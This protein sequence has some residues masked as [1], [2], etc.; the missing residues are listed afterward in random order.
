VVGLE[1]D[2]L[3]GLVQVPAH[4]AARDTELL[5]CFF[6][7]PTDSQQLHN[8]LLALRQVSPSGDEV[9]PIAGLVYESLKLW[10]LLVVIVTKIRIFAQ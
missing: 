5:T 1:T 8:F 6:N 3:G 9:K 4:S 7:L 10:I 2:M